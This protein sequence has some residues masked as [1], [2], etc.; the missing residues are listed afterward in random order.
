[1]NLDISKI[2]SEKGA[3]MDFSFNGGISKPDACN[4]GITFLEP[5]SVKGTIT[6]FKGQFL[7]EGFVTTKVS[8]LCSR[9]LNPVDIDI[10]FKL[11]ET[12]ASSDN[13]NNEIEIFKG[14][15]IELDDVL[16]RNIISKLPMKPLCSDDCKGLCPKCGMNLNDGN[17]SCNSESEVDPRF[18]KLRAIFKV[19]EEV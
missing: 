8:L 19:D 11:R 5:V 9:C 6:N 15:T 13:G 2:S 18:N 10:N 16:Y 14:N 12:F 4:P 17:C 7:A 3:S 1:M